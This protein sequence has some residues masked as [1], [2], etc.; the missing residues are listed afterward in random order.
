MGG[1]WLEPNCWYYS[2]EGRFYGPYSDRPVYWWGGY[3]YYPNAGYVKRDESKTRINILK[4][5]AKT[6]VEEFKDNQIKGDIRLIEFNTRAS[7]KTDWVDIQNDNQKAIEEINK[8]I[9][10][11][12]VQTQGGMD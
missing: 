3:Y 1:Q 12:G 5:Q 9:A 7:Y 10:D 4:N 2:D 8:L 11:G 6:L